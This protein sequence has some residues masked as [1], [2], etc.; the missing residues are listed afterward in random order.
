MK[1]KYDFENEK[2]IL[3]DIFFEQ[4]DIVDKKLKINIPSEIEGINIM[5][6]GPNRK[7]KTVL[8]I[9]CSP[10]FSYKTEIDEIVINICQNT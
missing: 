4:N 1:A 5:A 3:C 10:F 7:E 2:L 6:I 9:N 8:H